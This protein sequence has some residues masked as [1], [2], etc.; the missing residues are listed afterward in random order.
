MNFAITGDLDNPLASYIPSM[1]REEIIEMTH[2]TNF[3]DIQCHT[4]KL[5]YKMADGSAALIG[6]D[7]AGARK[8][9]EAEYKQRILNDTKTCVQKISELYPEPVD[10]FAYPFGIFTPL[11]TSLLMQSGIKYAFTVTPDM[12]TRGT[13]IMQIPRINAGNPS[14]TRKAFIHP[15]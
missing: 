14:I 9:T 10:S 7:N 6:L 2:D 5:H 1:S 13:D 15:Y 11:A 8:E 4:D 3:I 12:T